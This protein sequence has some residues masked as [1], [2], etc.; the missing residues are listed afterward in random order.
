MLL[1]YNLIQIALTI[2]LLPILLLIVIIT[3]KYRENARQRLGLDL[4]HHLEGRTVNGPCIWIHALSVGEVSSVRELVRVIREEY[5]DGYLVF[6][7]T[8]AI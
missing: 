8:T 7:A 3:P 6:S 5:P 2:L 1:I 4:R